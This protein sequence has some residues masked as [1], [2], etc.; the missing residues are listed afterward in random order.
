MA[1]RAYASE[2]NNLGINGTGPAIQAIY[3]V[4]DPSG[5]SAATA[6]AVG[7]NERR[8]VFTQFDAG[9]DTKDILDK[10]A[11]AIRSAEGD[12]GLRVTFVDE[13]GRY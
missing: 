11:D 3:I 1:N 12:S 13:R 9:D 6:T 8:A 4:V 10:I 5:A 7:G 2:F